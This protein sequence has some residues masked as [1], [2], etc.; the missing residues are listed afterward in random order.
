MSCIKTG[1]RVYLVEYDQTVPADIHQVG[2]CFVIDMNMSLFNTGDAMWGK[3]HSTTHIL[4]IGNGY[5]DKRGGV[6]VVPSRSLRSISD[7]NNT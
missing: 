7:D 1:A 3:H 4:R 5:W 6:A 2:D